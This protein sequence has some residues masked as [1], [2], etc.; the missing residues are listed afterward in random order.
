MGV[1]VE[2][3]EEE[4]KREREESHVCRQKA[5]VRGALLFCL[6]SPLCRNVVTSSSSSL[7]FLR[8]LSSCTVQLTLATVG[9]NIK[10]VAAE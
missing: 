6:L 1:Y 8:L 5:R 2:K 9:N 4:E 10:T 3:S 7:P